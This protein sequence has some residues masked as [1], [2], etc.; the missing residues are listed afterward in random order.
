M[1][2]NMVYR[3]ACR[4][5]FPT[6][7]VPPRGK[8]LKESYARQA[9]AQWKGP[10]I[11]GPVEVSIAIFFG[12]RRKCDWD[13]FHKLSMDALTGIAWEDDSQIQLATV[14][15]GYDKE[16][17]RMEITIKEMEHGR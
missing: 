7:Y 17:P 14:R 5:R 1:S 16:R 3:S 15:K 13:N 4:G 6:V 8:A 12:T 9:R 10:P 11:A 2:T